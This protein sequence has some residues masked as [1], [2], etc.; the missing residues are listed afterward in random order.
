MNHNSFNTKA[1]GVIE[2][3]KVIGIDSVNEGMPYCNSV[4]FILSM[5]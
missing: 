4:N 3:M 2:E 5:H 1:L